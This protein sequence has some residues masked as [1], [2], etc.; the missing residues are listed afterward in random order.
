ML[1]NRL[2]AALRQ[3]DEER[4][5]AEFYRMWLVALRAGFTHPKSMETMGVRQSGR[6]ESARRWL[7]VGT[8]RGRDLT[9]LV[10]SGGD[11]F[12]DFERALITL[13][14]ESGGLEEIVRQLGMFFSRKHKL[15]LW[16]RKKMAYP[17]FTAMAACFVAPVPLLYFGHASAYVICVVTGCVILLFSAETIVTAVAARYG[18]KP[19]LARARMASALATAIGAGI[20]LPRAVRL[21]ADASSNA[22]IQRFVESIDERR[23]ATSSLSESLAGCPHLTPDFLAILATAER[24]GDF[25]VLRRLS[26]LFDDGFS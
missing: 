12:D 11:R 4:H 21:S 24:T 9:S 15:M 6:T 23:L 18:R 22:R 19:L 14:E 1:M 10:Q 3:L 2:S 16:V 17:L 7:L 13:G 25:T 26:D 20:T 5:R 8:S